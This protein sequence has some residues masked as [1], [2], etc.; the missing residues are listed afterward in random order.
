[1][2]A[3]EKNNFAK[4][5]FRIFAV[6]IW[7]ADLIHFFGFVPVKSGAY[8]PKPYE[9]GIAFLAGLI[10]ATI[11]PEWIGTQLKNLISWLVRSKTK[12]TPN[13]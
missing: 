13:A 6:I 10:L 7:I 1:M 12:T 3:Q 2:T 9:I 8:V 4:Y 5:L 11:S